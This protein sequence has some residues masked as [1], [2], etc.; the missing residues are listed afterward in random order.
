MTFERDIRP[1]LKAHCFH[2]HGEDGVVEAN[3]DLQFKKKMVIGG[4]SGPA[5]VPGNS[6]ASLL[7]EMIVKGKMPPKGKGLSETELASLQRWVDE[8]AKTLRDEN[9]AHENSRYTDEERSFWAFQSPLDYPVPKPAQDQQ[10]AQPMDAFIQSG[11]ERVGLSFSPEASKQTLIRR[12][13]FDLTGLPPTYEEVVEFT[14]DNRPDGYERLVD[15]LMASP[16]YGE[17]W[18]RHWLDAAGYADSDGYTEQDPVREFAY[19]YRDYVI[20]SFNSGKSYDQF[21]KEQLAGDE[22]AGGVTAGGIEGELT[23]ERIEKLAA[24]GFL[25]TAQDGSASGGVDLAVSSNETISDTINIV[26]TSLLGLT[27]GC[28]RCHNHRY[29][30]ISH[31]DYHRMRA[32]FE[33]ALDWKAWR[34]PGQRQISLYTKSDYEKR[35]E[36]EKQAQVVEAER[37]EKQKAHLERTLYEELLVA[38]DEKRESLK[39]A[40][41]KPAAERSPE[42]IA[43]LEEHPNIGNINAGSLYLYAE[44]RERRAREIEAAANAR[45][46]RYIEEVR[47]AAIAEIPEEKRAAVQEAMNIE[48]AKRT[49]EQK[50][51]AIEFPKVFVTSESLLQ[52]APEKGAEI[53]EYRSA[54]MKC[55]ALDAKTELAQMQENASKIRAQAPKENFV[56]VLNEPANHQPPTHLFKRGNHTQP[57][58]VVPPGELE[59]LSYV[60]PGE[61]PLDDAQLST[62]G[63]R[64]AYANLLTNGK[65]PL[66]G[67]VFINRLW[68]HHFGKGIVASSGDFGFLGSR[69]TNA[70]LLDYLAY[71]FANEGWDIKRTQRM[72]VTS[73]TYRQSSTRTE[74]LDTT[75]PENRFLARMI[76]KRLESEIVRDAT[77]AVSGDLVLQLHGPPVP[78]KEDAVGQIVLGREVL[79]GER[80][81]VGNDDLGLEAAR[82]SIYVQVRRS[83][84]LAVLETF[85]LPA[86]A[87][88]C[89]Q[90]SSS[91][92]ALQSL[93][94]M[95]S[96]FSIQYAKKLANRVRIGE[97]DPDKQ[98]SRAVEFCYSRSAKE[99]ES[100]VLLSKYHSIAEKLRA[101]FPTWTDEQI[102]SQTLATICQALLSANEFI[103]VD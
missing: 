31:I 80:K 77:L 87:P 68:Q 61:I 84:P 60:N 52:F 18:A 93:M 88:N 29:D 40:Y 5:I 1:I 69:P 91:N 44:Q 64:L 9:A 94:L 12:L 50:Q 75:D 74:Q 57:A 25:R 32:I 45:E 54:A 22:L 67:R 48:D 100:Q 7:V 15:R 70:E 101:K 23:P 82:R 47:A 79:D 62:S 36:F 92:V 42:Q 8:G 30:P 95:N 10:F 13:Y 46:K 85:D 76:P 98:L 16:H 24:T 90:R 4:D 27:V 3:L 71:H 33:P 55:R 14:Q 59:I 83:R 99:S 26:S 43:L 73:K 28:A 66:V 37:N 17:R 86:L 89:S 81:P 11:L 97:A 49:E 41:L 78:V 96:D 63:R 103:Y 39:A 19:F 38:P 53:A 72:M 102:Q 21:I 20:D 2:C 34:A 58:D 51:I 56:R 35:A 6:S 65:H